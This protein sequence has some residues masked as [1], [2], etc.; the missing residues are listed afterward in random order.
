MGITERT[1]FS[2]PAPASA[3]ALPAAAAVADAGLRSRTLIVPAAEVLVGEALVAAKVATLAAAA[4][5]SSAVHAA[6]PRVL[7]VRIAAADV[8]VLVV[9]VDAGL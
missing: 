4:T 8:D 9:G 5:A 1:L 6:W 7:V 3:A 2:V